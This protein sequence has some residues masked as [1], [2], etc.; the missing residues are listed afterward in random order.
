MDAGKK[1][2][3]EEE[4]F[5]LLYALCGI[6]LTT[7]IVISIFVIANNGASQI[8]KSDAI[9]KL[10]Q[11]SDFSY[12]QGE[13]KIKE[14]IQ[15]EIKKSQS[16]DLEGDQPNLIN[17]IS[18]SVVAGDKIISGRAGTDKQ[19]YYEVT[20]E[21]VSIVKTPY[22]YVQSISGDNYGGW[23]KEESSDDSKKNF[24]FTACL[25]IYGVEEQRRTSDFSKEINYNYEFQIDTINQNEIL[26]NMDRWRNVVSDLGIE[27]NSGKMSAMEKLLQMDKIVHYQ[28]D[29]LKTM[30]ITDYLTENNSQSGISLGDS[31]LNISDFKND[32]GLDF[33]NNPF[34]R[35]LEF[36]G[37]LFLRGGFK[38]QGNGS[39]TLTTHNILEVSG[40]K[41]LLEENYFKGVPILSGTGVIFDSLSNQQQIIID[42]NSLSLPMLK[43]PNLII[44]NSNGIKSNSP[45]T[46]GVALTSGIIQ[47]SNNNQ[48]IQTDFNRYQSSIGQS[49]P[50]SIQ[51]WEAVM[52]PS[53]I[54]ASSN[55][56]LGSVKDESAQRQIEVEGDFLLTSAQATRLEGDSDEGIQLSYF[57]NPDNQDYEFPY[58]PANIVLEGI[59]TSLVVGNTN[60]NFTT[61]SFIDAP[62]IQVRESL[63][64]GNSLQFDGYYTNSNYYNSIS[65]SGGAQMLLGYTGVEPF[66]FSISENSIFSMKILPNLEFFDLYFIR[67]AY[68]H[69]DLKGKVILE[70]NSEVDSDKLQDILKASGVPYKLYSSGIDNDQ[71][72]N[73]YVTVVENATI[74]SGNSSYLVSRM[75]D[76]SQEVER[77]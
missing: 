29:F 37:S 51:N 1:I 59:N 58:S 45:K 20:L 68:E 60:N 11:L 67:T 47:I 49:N 70:V 21:T 75:F 53:L 4:G 52:Q 26:M 44:S 35:N 32:T 3:Q 69:G 2:I 17:K 54:V 46:S 16:I 39:S 57:E 40:E 56:Y 62:K 77:P 48:V 55:L 64:N 25:K 28:D 15:E 24:L 13:E 73:G 72:I 33:V 38:F 27:Q 65:L 63:T 22:H 23:K 9:V 61:Y 43:S 34:D 8:N 50:Q 74:N 19:F 71:A 76:F 31:G 7:L 6:V 5:A 10:S 66:N 36:Q 41:S 12:Q 42:D 30:D 14:I 18:Q